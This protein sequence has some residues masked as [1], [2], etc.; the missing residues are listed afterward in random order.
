MAQ[1]PRPVI[2]GFHPD[3]SVVRVEEDYFL[4]TSSFEYFPGVPLF[5]STNL[6]DWTQIGHVLNRRAQL[7]LS[8]AKPSGGI[9]APTIRHHGG[10]FWMI[11]TNVDDDGGQI[12]VSATD[13]RGPW[14][15]PVRIPGAAGIDPD[16]AWD[17]AGRLFVTFATFDAATIT[18]VIRQ[19]EVDPVTGNVQ[20]EPIELWQGTGHKFPEGPHLYRINDYWYL[21]LAEG[22][23]ERGHSVVIARGP[24]PQGPFEANPTG[25]ILTRR[26]Y[27]GTLQNTGHADLVQRPDGS[28]AMVFLGVRVRGGSHGFHGLG[29]ETFA[30]E[31]R[32]QDGWPVVGDLLSPTVAH[33]SAISSTVTGTSSGTAVSTV[34]DVLTDFSAQLGY[35]WV[36]SG[37]ASGSPVAALGDGSLLLNSA[38]YSDV[39]LGRRQ[40]QLFAEATV[41]IEPGSGRGALV[42]RLT[43]THEYS[44]E[45]S[46]STVAAVSQV[47]AVRAV[48]VQRTHSTEWPGSSRESTSVT[49]YVAVVPETSGSGG[50]DCVAL[51]YMKDGERV[52]LARL[53]G[54]YLCT[55]VAGGFTGR[56]FGIVS[57]DGQP[58][59]KHFRYRGSDDA[60]ALA[61]DAPAV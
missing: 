8:R 34:T 4:V 1:E 44:V 16:L 11:T 58:A 28:W 47:G 45:V 46:A 15:D 2:P 26:G 36:S 25:P 61:L 38:R 17:D 60:T 13:P 43:P 54:R 48:V 23:T 14:S 5:H 33:P 42:L 7:D 27:P 51:G 19:A 40:E 59:F 18:S 41:S 32:W 6:T 3:P 30:A 29:R 31:V 50:P 57:A 55:E 53:D 12:L 37:P 22:G 24:T 39:F 20:G 9:Y 56:L 10:R 52:E 21:M 49:V 35:E